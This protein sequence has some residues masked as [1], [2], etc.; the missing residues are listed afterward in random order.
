[1]ATTA[2]D[3]ALQTALTGVQSDVFDYILI[4]LPIAL[5]I[6]AVFIGVRLALK[7]FRQVAH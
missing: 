4:A 7:F 6:M 2:I 1:M 3:A 5:G